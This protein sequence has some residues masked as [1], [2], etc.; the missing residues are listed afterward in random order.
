MV[1]E[2]Y[3]AGF[4]K[5][6]EAHG[7]DPVELA[8]AAAGPLG[9]AGRIGAG[10]TG[11]GALAGAVPGAALG[12][13]TASGIG[14]IGTGLGAAAGGLIGAGAGA[15]GAGSLAAGTAAGIGAR[16]A[17]DGL[18]GGGM[19]AGLERYGDRV[20]AFLAKKFGP[21]LVQ[22]GKPASPAAQASRAGAVVAQ[23]GIGKAIR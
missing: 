4:A 17:V 12:S 22:P 15:L 5:M 19:T 8:K 10:L 21:R 1:T 2:A 6:A 7:I 13:F 9:V 3:A 14:G 16:K 20:G 18:T 11:A 23:N